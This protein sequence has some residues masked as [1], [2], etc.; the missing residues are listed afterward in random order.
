MIAQKLHRHHIQKALN[1]IY[2]VRDANTVVILE[3]RIIVVFIDQADW[4]SST[5]SN[6]LEC[7][8]QMLNIILDRLATNRVVPIL[9]HDHEDRHIAVNQGKGSVLELSSKDSLRVNIAN[10]LDL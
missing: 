5:S 3:E 7:V 10:F 6:L 4:F 1:C 9:V 8:F 2:R